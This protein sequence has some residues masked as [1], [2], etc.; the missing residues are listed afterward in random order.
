MFIF[1]YDDVIPKNGSEQQKLC[2]ENLLVSAD[3]PFRKSMRPEFI[4]LAPPLHVDQDEVIYQMEIFI[5]F[6]MFNIVLCSLFLN[7]YYVHC[8]S[9]Y[10][11]HIIIII[12]N[13]FINF[14]KVNFFL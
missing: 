12:I 3:A 1:S 4:R 7:Y 13:L 9:I 11:V 5:Y 6:I 2:L 10:N 14:L 8:Y